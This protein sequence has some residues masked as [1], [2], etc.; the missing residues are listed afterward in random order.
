MDLC[1]LFGCLIFGG[2]KGVGVG[3]DVIGYGFVG[4]VF[5]VF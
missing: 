3:Y 5:L 1:G 2:G 4:Y